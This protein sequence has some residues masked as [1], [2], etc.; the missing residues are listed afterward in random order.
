MSIQFVLTGGLTSM[1]NP[2]AM[3]AA[4]ADAVIKLTSWIENIIIM[5]HSTAKPMRWMMKTEL[6]RL[7]DHNSSLTCRLAPPA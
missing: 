1:V 3:M 5:Y 2:A 7:S 6:G 4:I